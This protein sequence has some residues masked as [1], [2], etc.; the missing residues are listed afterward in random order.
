MSKL[1][2]RARTPRQIIGDDALLQLTFEG[3]TV[4]PS[5]PEAEPVAWRWRCEIFREWNLSDRRPGS[6]AEM[7]RATELNMTGLEV[8]PLFAASV[9]LDGLQGE[10]ERLRLMLRQLGACMSCIDGPADPHGC[11]D[12]LNTGWEGGEPAGYVAEATLTR[13]TAE[14]DEAVRLL[15]PLWRW[16]AAGTNRPTL[17]D[18]DA[19]VA[20]LSRLHQK[21]HR[22]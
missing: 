19:I 4:V 15:E 2:P 1:D 10:I 12:C 13:V 8:Q 9:E 11:T 21:G 3:Y 18:L 17:D 20:F 22:Q 5:S 16:A 14:R 7:E 6:Q